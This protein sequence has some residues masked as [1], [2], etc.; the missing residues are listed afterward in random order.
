MEEKYPAENLHLIKLPDENK[1]RIGLYDEKTNL[2]YVFSKN[3]N[4][5]ANDIR[6][7]MLT[8]NRPIQSSS[9]RYA[10][11]CYPSDCL[12]NIFNNGGSEANI[13][14][15]WLKYY[16]LYYLSK[17][18]ILELEK[19]FQ[20]KLKNVNKLLYPESKIYNDKEK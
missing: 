19:L 7:I 6:N 11:H 1:A 18:E 17:P 12:Y 16:N 8:P 20:K 2:L 13:L 9:E 10:F 4:Y 15:N 14:Y 5:H 3:T